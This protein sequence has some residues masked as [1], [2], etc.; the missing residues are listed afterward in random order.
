MF[1]LQPKFLDLPCCRVLQY[2]TKN[3]KF[4]YYDT[5]QFSFQ[6]KD[7]HRRSLDTAGE[8]VTLPDV[9]IL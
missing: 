6:K 4:V 2:F 9:S 3:H 7:F 8:S 1:Q 5:T